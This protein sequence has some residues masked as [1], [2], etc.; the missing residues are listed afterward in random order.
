VIGLG[1]GSAID[2][3]KAIA[4]LLPN[5][6]DPLD[7][8]EV[9]GRGQP[10]LKPAAPF[11]AIPTT[12]GTG[13][14]VT[15]NAVLTSPAHGVKASLRSPHM[16]AKVALVDP[17]LL[18]GLP[19]PIIAASGLDALSQ[20]VEPFVSCRA[21]PLT[22]ALC[23]DGIPR[24]ADALPRAYEGDLAPDVRSDLAL[25]SLFG[26][27]ALAN[28]GLGAVHGFAAP[29]GGMF[30]APHGALCAALLASV[31]EVN[32][33]AL[34]R[35]APGSRALARYGEIARMLAGRP[36]PRAAVDAIRSLTERLGVPRLAQH[37]VR[38]SDISEVVE[39]AEAASSMRGNPIALTR[40]ELA[41]ILAQ[42]L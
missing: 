42:A 35:R 21:N 33:L 32:I 41:A 26:G 12:A 25:A 9:V 37:G 40:E 7:Y 39:R 30:A 36:E 17:D 22:D 3:A 19:P 18:A 31:M 11:L 15:R 27:L 34:E 8:L 16:L 23:R 20:L 10:L 24:S 28:A 14:E 1:G 4:A 29:L 13:A 5:G 2:A 38:P 6:G